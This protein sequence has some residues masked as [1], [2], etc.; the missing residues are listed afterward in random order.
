MTVAYRAPRRA[1]EKAAENPRITTTVPSG[2]QNA[3]LSINESSFT[4]HS[5]HTVL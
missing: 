1:C 4:V 5:V 3:E 2:S